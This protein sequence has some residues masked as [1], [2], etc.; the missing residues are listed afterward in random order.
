[1]PETNIYR[2]LI[3]NVACIDKT[4]GYYNFTF[5]D[6]L[7]TRKKTQ[8]PTRQLG[9]LRFIMEG[10]EIA[11]MLIIVRDHV[12]VISRCYEQHMS[13]CGHNIIDVDWGIL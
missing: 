6:K 4:H 2:F 8:Q 10:L 11:S 3:R 12:R 7:K 9:L 5:V 1:M 13:I